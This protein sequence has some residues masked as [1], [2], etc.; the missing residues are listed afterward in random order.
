MFSKLGFGD[1]GTQGLP[2]DAANR[3]RRGQLRGTIEQMRV[4]LLGN[5]LFAPALS[6][7]AWGAGA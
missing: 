3:L 7:N 6:M 5:T 1:L 4:M 2:V